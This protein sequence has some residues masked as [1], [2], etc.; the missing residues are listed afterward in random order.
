MDTDLF[1]TFQVQFAI[2][3]IVS[4]IY[5]VSEKN[6][7]LNDLIALS[8]I[9]APSAYADM[10]KTDWGVLFWDTNNPTMHDT[11]HACI[12]KEEYFSAALKEIQAFYT[13]KGLTPRIYLCGN[14]KETQAEILLKNGYRL[15]NVGAFQHFLLTEQNEILQ[16]HQIEIRELTE[17][18][19]VTERLLQNLYSIYQAED[20]DTI[21]R[22][23]RILVRCIESKQCRV[24]CGYF[25]ND[26]ACLAMTVDSPYGM[27]CF[28]LV[29]TAAIYQNRGFARELISFLVNRAERPTFLYSENPTA[30]R[31]YTQA[32]FRPVE[33]RENPVY[34][35]AVYE[36]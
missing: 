14:Q 36:A 22:S 20:P 16:T 23:S 5:I 4:D 25:K 11:N 26:P 15:Y 21:N 35:R 7:T 17:K 6:M 1:L 34:W 31:I 27:Q 12:L 2:V 13:Q 32:G 19:A 18:S 8:D 24:W 30:I 10:Q 33:M 3:S 9:Y 28:D 29:E